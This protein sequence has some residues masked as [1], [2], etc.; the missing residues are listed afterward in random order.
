MHEVGMI[1]QA[2]GGVNRVYQG[3]QGQA[4][5]GQVLPGCGWS[6]VGG[7]QSQAGFEWSSD[8]E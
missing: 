3:G 6:H 4:G 8:K 5:G 2:V 7:G 1:Y